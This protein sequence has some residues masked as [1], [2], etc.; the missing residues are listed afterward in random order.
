VSG[1]W[2]GVRAESGLYPRHVVQRKADDIQSSV[3]FPRDP[4]RH[5]TA[6]PHKSAESIPSISTIFPQKPLAPT[7]RK[8]DT[9]QPPLRYG[10]RGASIRSP[11]GPSTEPPGR[12]GPDY[13]PLAE[14]LLMTGSVLECICLLVVGWYLSYEPYLGA[15]PR[16][17]CYVALRAGYEA[18]RSYWLE[19]IRPLHMLSISI[20]KK[21]KHSGQTHRQE[22][23]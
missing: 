7:R 9:V 21:K 10:Q 14:L 1:V 12:A 2:K 13:L 17:F 6:H 4:R 22:C 19:N 20:R 5:S 16:S 11:R 3:A 23:P 18:S 8:S 15:G